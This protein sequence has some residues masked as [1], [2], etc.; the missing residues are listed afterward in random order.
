MPAGK[1]VFRTKTSDALPTIPFDI[2]LENAAGE[3]RTL[4]FH[5]YGEPPAGALLTMASLIR[6]NDKGVEFMDP[7]RLGQAFR[8]AIVRDERA[9]WETEVMGDTSE[10]MVPAPI[11]GEVWEWLQAEVWERPTGPS[12][13]SSG[14]QPGNGAGSTANAPS[15]EPI[16]PPFSTETRTDSSQS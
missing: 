6:V 8:D 11:L 7:S 1:K 3:K 2:E 10:W 13:G 4:E 15:T 9:R 16:S 12:S 14:T 5:A